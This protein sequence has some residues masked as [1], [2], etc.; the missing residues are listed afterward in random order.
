MDESAVNEV[1]DLI[2]T[3]KRETRSAPKLRRFDDL[4]IGL[5]TGLIEPMKMASSLDHWL[6]LNA[7]Y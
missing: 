1:L 5:I 6:T 2:A 4:A 3:M 7:R